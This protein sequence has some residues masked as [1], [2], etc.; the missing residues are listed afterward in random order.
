MIRIRVPALSFVAAAILFAGC[1]G[2]S[3]VATK[4]GVTAPDPQWVT[5]I[6][7]HSNGAISRHSP[8]RVLF[9]NDV[10]PQE[11][12]GTDAA[13]N[14]SITPA[15]KVRATFASRREI[16]LRAEP[17][18][19][20]GTDYRVSVR[21]RGLTGVEPD[22]KP[23]EFMVRTLGVNFDVQTHGLDV[24]HARNE[25]MILRGA[26][27]TAD[28]ED[29]ERIEKIV[30]ATLDGKPLPIVWT[31]GENQ[32][33]FTISGIVRKREEQE[34]VLKWDGA[35]LNVENSGSQ[36]WRVPALDEFAVTQAEA[37]Q[38]N[39][40]RQ[41][42][43]RFSDALDA[44]QELKGH[45]RLSQGEFT[46]SI[47][48]N[49]LTLYLNNDVVG[50]V[51]LTLESAIRSRSGQ[52]LIGL[53][54]FKLEFTNTKPQVR[55]VGKGVILPDAATLSVPFE[56]VS[57]R[58]VRVTALQV[59][60]ANIPQFLQVNP[61]GGSQQL[62]RVGRVLWRKTIPL[63][64]PVPGKWTRY[65]LDVTE[66]M[67][68]HPGGLFQLTLSLAPGDALYDCPGGSET[69]PPEDPVPAS[70]EDGD[71]GDY[72]NWDYYQEE[73]EGEINWNERDDP[74]KPAYYRYGR[75]IRAARNL[76]ASNIGLIA[77]RAQR[78]KLLAVATAL[79][80]AKPLAGVKID[81]MSFQNQ[82]M[83]SGRTD[84]NGM[85]E[86]D[87]RG[88]VFALIA[89]DGGRKGYLRVAN[90]VALPV[91]HFD[92]GGETVVAGLKGFLYGDRGVWRPG[93]PIYLTFALQ[94]RAGTLP[95]DH[96]VTVE[97]RNPRGQLVQTLTN[98]KPVGQFYA[99]ELNTTADAPTG[100]W[101]VLA[102]VGGA[103]FSKT[104]KVETVMPNRLKIDLDLGEKEVI[105]SSPLKGAVNAQWLSG[106]TAASLRAAIEVRLSSAPTRF[107]RNA[108][109]VFDDPARSFSGAPITVYDGEL[110]A[111]GKAKFEKNLDL[112]RDVPGMLNAT[113]ITRV[114][115]RGGAFSINRETRTV[116]AFDRYVGL[117]LPKGDAARDMLLTDTAHTVELATL[118]ADG[119]PASVPRLQVSIYKVQWRWWWDSSGD[120]LAQYA[121]GEST[122]MIAQETIASK[123]GRGQWKFEVKYPEWGRYLIR[124]CD[125]DGGHCTGRVFYIDWPSWAGAARDQSGP[126]AN[127][128]MLTSDKQEYR[129]GETALVQLPEASQGRALLTLESGSAILEQ[130]WIEAKPGANRIS[131]P[132]TAG[133]AP[134]IYAAVTMVQP[135]AGKA[136]DRP[137]RLY[138]VIPLKVS[139]PK[140]H[141]V[142]Q[143]TTAAEWAPQSKASVTVSEK[144]GRAMDYTLAV[145]DEGLLGLTG[146]RTPNLH[147][148]FYKREALGV[149]TWDLFD[150][151]AGAYGGQLDRLLALG[152]SDASAATNPDEAKSRFPPVV[153]FLGPFSLKAGEKRAH[154]LELPQYVGAVRVMVVAGDGSAYG[155]ADKSV[156]VRQALMILPTLPRV[157][158]PDEQF[159][160]PVS[161]FTSDASIRTVNLEIQTDARFSAVG[162]PATQIAFTRPEEK[163]GFLRVRSGTTL[164]QGRI[165]VVATSGRFRAEHDVWLEVRAPNTPS[166]RFLRAT[167]APG[168]SW[169]GDLT[170]FGLPGTQVANLE[171]SA[172]PPV[173]V[174]GRLEYLIHYPY[175]CL[176]QTTSSVFPQLY[177][178]ALIKLDQNRRLEVE[179]NV[180]AGLARLRSLQH[181]SGGFAYWP[182][183]WNTDGGRD[184]RNNWGTTYA[185][186]FFLEA[187]KAG[188]TLPGDMKSSWLRYQKDAAQQWNPRR[189][190]PG[191]YAPDL[192]HAERYAQAYRLYTLALAGQAE[193]GAMN[194]LRENS[195]LTLPERWL[196]ASAYHLAG[197]ADVARTMVEKDRVQA[198]VF[199]DANP[200]TFGSLLRDRAVVLMGLTLLGREAET[201]ALLEDVAAQLSDGSW[202][203]TQSVAF[204]L[205]A[206]AHNTGAKP[207][208]GFG[209]DYSVAARKQSVKGEA[210]VAN[211]KLPPPPAS[212]LPLTLTN[213]S[214]RK[215]YATVGVRAVPRSGE[216]DSSANGLSIDV[217]YGDADGKVLDI[218]SVTQ[219]LDLIAQVTVKNLSKR[220]LDN[221]A[222][223]QLVP[224][225][226]EIRNDRLEGVDTKGVTAGPQPLAQFW[227]VPAQWRNQAMRTAEYVDIRDDRVQRFFSL[228]PG[229]SI[230][231]ETRLNAAY[232]GRFYLPGAGVEAMYDATQHARVKGQWVE[233]VSPQ[234]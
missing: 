7:Q 181:S 48:G 63:A 150:E 41:I 215:L 118:D 19:A 149:S 82:V 143:V 14:I 163:L 38:V 127:V 83:A 192:A 20:P 155:S 114:F 206:V 51:A 210:P 101:N 198:F 111:D 79:D 164:G 135:H 76:L 66:L 148:E 87:A 226:W 100:D 202:Y 115:E 36:S 178:P 116:A 47:N 194:R 21:A 1:S 30:T 208:T 31:A 112:P 109:Y 182:G 96:P 97:L 227:W 196:L 193:I 46:T 200:Y 134:G 165:R 99:F 104:L 191:K 174:D 93:D 88:N 2:S 64:S 106:A 152:G 15:V 170:A 129:V 73:Y 167:L 128:L 74:C 188:Y 160:L 207:F 39:D 151:V 45:V 10:V 29:R 86:L 32:H 171:V 110:D 60:E 140:T 6:S 190:E 8:V 224:A 70:Q 62:G 221:L 214:D 117:R 144:S 65:D 98:S 53:R 71:T 234:R 223:S 146:F 185:G 211:I 231:F 17:E 228:G 44:R 157:I 217:Q 68:K 130:R 205:V 95:P 213:T 156:F 184:W 201:G 75:N 18:F 4:P 50:E 94:D 26:V 138:G 161:V 199:A 179:N 124:A 175:G 5:S 107:T 131:I 42:H 145:V 219:G 16:V 222:L 168:E 209:F 23:F 158:G 232:L 220:Q 113:F 81:A 54:E 189:D 49:L 40:Q 133:M 69:A 43:V 28:T 159:S 139:D 67:R 13:A 72:S 187:E 183:I 102:H 105:E 3:S 122:A 90:G 91:S 147:A 153:R 125:L 58:A 216:E 11:R 225:G 56:A 27:L 119:R 85:L 24:E 92:V 197:K 35:P 132:I 80:S 229:E 203:S 55:F 120:S 154:S 141:L 142:P 195:S 230:F 9:T 177:L 173:N 37:V 172:L 212:G 176:E 78:G 169:K 57:A 121:Q 61:L 25:L 137:I 123:D 34:V 52:P 103:S 84:S 162:S 12:V 204:A 126:A 233:V 180:R 218:R 59:F 22:T 33:G 166:S 89:D 186:H 108:D 136:N 77:K